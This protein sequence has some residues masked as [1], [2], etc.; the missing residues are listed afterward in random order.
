MLLRLTLVSLLLLLPG[1]AQAEPGDGFARPGGYI[2][3]GGT[4]AFHWFP[5]NFDEDVTGGPAVKTENGGGLNVRGGYRFNSWAAL[6]GEYEWIAGFENKVPGQ[7]LFDLS[8]HT[9]TANGKFIYPG[10]GRFQPYGLV[11]IG[12]TIL[13]LD[14]QAAQGLFLDDTTVGFATRFGAGLDVYLSENWLFNAAVEMQVS[15]AT[16]ENSNPVGND[17]GSLFYIPVQFGF[18][19]RF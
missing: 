6:E 9:V 8:Y 11:G 10:W 5:G 4:Y 17:V 15:T 16:I 3:I 18:Q 14:D 7:K 13:D 19:Y 12:F 2:G 1:L